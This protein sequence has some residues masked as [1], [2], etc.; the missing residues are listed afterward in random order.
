MTTKTYRITWRLEITMHGRNYHRRA[1]MGMAQG[2]RDVMNR[3]W[4]FGRTSRQIKVYVEE[5]A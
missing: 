3:A 4:S 2:T 1:V 5:L